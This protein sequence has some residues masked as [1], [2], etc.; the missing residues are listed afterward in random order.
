MKIG[1]ELAGATSVVLSVIPSSTPYG[2][3]IPP[4]FSIVSGA[5]ERNC[6]VGPGTSA[7]GSETVTEAVPVS[8]EGSVAVAVI[9]CEVPAAAALNVTEEEH[10]VGGV[11]VAPG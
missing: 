2:T 9:V 5:I 1:G 8:P 6:S 4:L 3:M 7:A 11:N 10:P